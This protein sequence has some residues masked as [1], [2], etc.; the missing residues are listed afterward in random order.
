MYPFRVALP[1]GLTVLIGALPGCGTPAAEVVEP[2]PSA[3]PAAATE[4]LLYFPP[5]DGAWETVEPAD[6]GCVRLTGLS[7]VWRCFD[8][9]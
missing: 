7:P 2:E 1:F 3:A 5:A 9:W 4:A 6:L 8:V